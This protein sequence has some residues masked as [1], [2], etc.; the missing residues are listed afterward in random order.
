MCC[1]IK[2]YNIAAIKYKSN[3]R[4]IWNLIN[5]IVQN[6]CLQTLEKLQLKSNK[7]LKI[8]AQ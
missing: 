3:S 4:E 8:L 1:K 6:R 7:K 5:K 2:Y